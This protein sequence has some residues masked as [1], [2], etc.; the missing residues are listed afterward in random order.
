VSLRLC[1]AC[2]T[3]PPGK[4]ASVY[5]SWLKADRARVAYRQFLCP[6][7]VRDVI[8]PLLEPVDGSLLMCPMCHAP[9]DDDLDP[10]YSKVYVPGTD[11]IALELATDAV[12][13]A[14]LRARALAGAEQL[15]DRGAEFGG[16][17]P[18]PSVPSE[19]A[20]LGIVP[21]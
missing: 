1:G 7:C 8:L 3:R 16:Q 6:S 17:A 18:K 5:W 4:I 20:A 10:V 11:P 15:E 2:G 9:S 21:R 12:C 19:W 13:A 14:E